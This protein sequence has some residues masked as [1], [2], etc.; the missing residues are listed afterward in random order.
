MDESPTETPTVVVHVRL[1]ALNVLFRIEKEARALLA[2]VDEGT[3]RWS[4]VEMR[5]ELLRAALEDFDR[6]A[7]LGRVR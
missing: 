7:E 5:R 4:E 2:A 3:S 6:L 1:A